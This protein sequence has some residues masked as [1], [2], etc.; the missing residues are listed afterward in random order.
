MKNFTKVQ[1]I[2][3]AILLITDAVKS[4]ALEPLGIKKAQADGWAKYLLDRKITF[5]DA[6]DIFQNGDIDVSINHLLSLCIDQR[7]FTKKTKD[8]GE[9]QCEKEKPV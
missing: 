9:E 4:E 7:F 8:I 5:E 6:M 2:A 1:R 3:V